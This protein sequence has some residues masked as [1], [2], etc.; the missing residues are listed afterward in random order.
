MPT[1]LDQFPEALLSEYELRRIGSGA[2][3]DVYRHKNGEEVLRVPHRTEADLIAR[4]G[5]SEGDPEMSLTTQLEIIRHE[6]LITHLGDS[7]VPV[8]PFKE[9]DRLGRLRTY[10]TQPYISIQEGHPLQLYKGKHVPEV[11]RES[12]RSFIDRVRVLIQETGLIPDLAG[13]QNVVVDKSGSVLLVDVN[14]V[15]RLLGEEWT[16]PAGQERSAY[17]RVRSIKYPPHLLHPEYL[18]DHRFPVADTSLYVLRTWEHFLG[19]STSELDR[20]PLYGRLSSNSTR[21]TVL[22]FILNESL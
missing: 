8:K 10:S 12:L 17:D 19:H 5:A 16:L 13:N 1:D 11:T 20:D 6:L 22:S 15:R 18:D 14:N 21:D 2:R 3:M 7:M 9:L 4:N